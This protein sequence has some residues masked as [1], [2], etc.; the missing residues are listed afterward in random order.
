M[1]LIEL[2]TTNYQLKEQNSKNSA[3]EYYLRVMFSFHSVKGKIS[4]DDRECRGNSGCSCF[5]GMRVAVFHCIR[6]ATCPI[7]LS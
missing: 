5:K 6:I 1:Q 3:G 7:T 4:A 2:R